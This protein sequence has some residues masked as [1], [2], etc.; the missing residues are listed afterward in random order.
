MFVHRVLYF[1]LFQTSPNLMK[2]QRTISRKD[3]RRPIYLQNNTET[4]YY[5]SV[6]CSNH[7]NGS[8]FIPYF[9]Q[10]NRRPFILNIYSYIISST[11]Y[12]V[13][14]LN[15][16]LLRVHVKTKR[17]NRTF[18]SLTSRVSMSPTE[19]QQFHLV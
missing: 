2:L 14:V 17:K 16:T 1:V 8:H 4:F 9:R 5:M 11:L 6:T 12:Q 19:S 13:S 10:L 18:S 15:F 3:Y 7:F